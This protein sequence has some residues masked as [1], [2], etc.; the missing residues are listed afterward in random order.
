[1]LPQYNK[2]AYNVV[3]F[4]LF[5]LIALYFLANVLLANVY[6]KYEKRLVREDKEIVKMME[7]HLVDMLDRI[8]GGKH[9]FHLDEEQ[10][11][12]FFVEVMELDI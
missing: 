3:P 4:I 8:T 10:T 2:H 1:M 6:N 7:E 11:K 9:V 12:R 5:L